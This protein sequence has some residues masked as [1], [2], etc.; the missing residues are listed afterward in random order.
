MEW[1]TS[2]TEIIIKY[3]IPKQSLNS[4]FYLTV[5]LFKTEVQISKMDVENVC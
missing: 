5:L 4:A 2:I 1:N 3:L